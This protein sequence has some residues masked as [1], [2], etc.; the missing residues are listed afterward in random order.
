MAG[1]AQV[2]L[3]YEAVTGQ[4]PDYTKSPAAQAAAGEAAMS[5]Q[6]A[7]APGQSAA[8]APKPTLTPAASAPSSA[9]SQVTPCRDL[10]FGAT[11]IVASKVLHPHDWALPCTQARA[12]KGC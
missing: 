2:A 10:L 8:A 3:L 12:H 4:V 6:S 7:A 5:P 1:A 9:G 11:S